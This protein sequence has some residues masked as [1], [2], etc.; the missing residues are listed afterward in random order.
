MVIAVLT[1]DSSLL[2]EKHQGALANG[3]IFLCYEPTDRDT[4]TP[5]QVQH[6][7]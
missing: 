2:W 3:G 6:E 4:F 7:C 5:K 1:V